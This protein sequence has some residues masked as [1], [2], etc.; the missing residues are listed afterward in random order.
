MSADWGNKQQETHIC[1]WPSMAPARSRTAQ[2]HN[3]TPYQHSF[4][5]HT[6]DPASPTLCDRPST[7]MH[8]SSGRNIFQDA[9]A[10]AEC[11]ELEVLR[12]RSTAA[13]HTAD[14]RHS[15]GSSFGSPTSRAESL[16]TA[17][18]RGVGAPI[19]TDVAPKAVHQAA[20]AAAAAGASHDNN[21]ASGDVRR[22]W[23]NNMEVQR[24]KSGR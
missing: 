17:T 22:R 8:M 19:F 6:Q 5:P 16:Q 9:R 1:M 13:A 11:V 15:R 14:N 3:P 24:L 7:M 18:A 23:G 12:I 20:A 2:L 4:G 21:A 10:I